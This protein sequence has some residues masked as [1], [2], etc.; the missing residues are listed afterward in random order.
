[1]L[2]A[3]GSRKNLEELVFYAF[4]SD[5]I[6]SDSVQELKNY[7]H[8]YS[9][10]RFQH[11]LNV[12]YYN[13]KLC[14]LFRLNARAAARGGL[15]HDLFYYNR[16]DYIRSKGECFHNA[17]HP[18]IAFE[19]AVREFDVSDLEKDII[20]KHMWPMTPLSLPKHRES[21]II[22]LV[23]KYCATLEILAVVF[24]AISKFTRIKTRR[25]KA[26]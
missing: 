18:Q 24:S 2:K 25:R 7:T 23:D 21:I 4:I 13:Y 6:N 3:I 11:S 5:I 9:T 8:H 15:L 26:A 16:R 14:Q 1:M 22:V 19:N 10:T 17:R 20:L 12:S